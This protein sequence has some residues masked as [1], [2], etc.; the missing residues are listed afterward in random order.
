[1]DYCV[2]LLLLKEFVIFDFLYCC[3]CVDDAWVQ[4][5][6]LKNNCLCYWSTEEF[7]TLDVTK[8]YFECID[9]CFLMLL[10]YFGYRCFFFSVYVDNVATLLERVHGKWENGDWLELCSG[11]CINWNHVKS[12]NNSEKWCDIVILSNIYCIWSKWRTICTVSEVI[13]TLK[14]CFLLLPAQCWIV[15]LVYN[16]VLSVY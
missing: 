15:I 1:M 10:S 6:L 8:D 13:I 5:S 4:L 14:V 3:E 12:A 16:K 7:W 2:H 9:T 11:Q